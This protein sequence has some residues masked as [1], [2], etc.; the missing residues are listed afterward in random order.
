[1]Q[2]SCHQDRSLP[3]LKKISSFKIIAQCSKANGDKL[4]LPVSNLGNTKFTPF[5]VPGWYCLLKLTARV[6]FS[7]LFLW[8]TSLTL[9]KV[10]RIHRKSVH[11]QFSL[12]STIHFCMLR[13]QVIPSKSSYL[14]WKSWCWRCCVH[15]AYLSGD[16]YLKELK[17]H[18]WTK[19]SLNHVRTFGKPLPV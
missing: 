4:T 16:F 15:P 19:T 1:M 6:L 9:Q 2:N 8:C 3:L 12:P 10:R 17:L 7:Y 13:Y 5:L 11:A 18:P 14:E